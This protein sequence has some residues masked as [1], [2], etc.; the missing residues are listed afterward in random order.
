MMVLSS[1]S[2]ASSPAASWTPWGAGD[3]YIAGFLFGL[4]RGKSIPDC[5]ALGAQSSSVT[6]QY[7]GA[8]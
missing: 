4:L 8:W 1:T 5:M 6:L 3:S 7:S 2:T